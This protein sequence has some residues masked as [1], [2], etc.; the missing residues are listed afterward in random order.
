MLRTQRNARIELAVALAVVLLG[1]WLG[2]PARDWAVL[3]LTIGV[4]LA[5]EI[6]NTVVEAMV[7]LVSPAYH[8]RAKHAKDAAAGAVLVLA[9]TAVL[10]GLYI[11]G[12][13][14]WERLASLR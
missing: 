7:D 4:V 1:L 5:A 12:P 13:P 8:D 3:W 11:L 2:L 6:I 9:I 14:L 10:V